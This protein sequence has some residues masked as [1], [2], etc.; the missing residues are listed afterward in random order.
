VQGGAFVGGCH[1][2]RIKRYMIDSKPG[3]EDDCFTPGWTNRWLVEYSTPEQYRFINWRTD[4]SVLT[5]VWGPD[6]MPHPFGP[7]CGPPPFRIVNDALLYPSCWQ[8]KLSPACDLSGLFT[9]RLMVEDT[10][11]GLYCDTQRV[12]I[13][14]KPITA[15]IKIDVVPEC[16]DVLVSR[17]AMPPDCGLPWPLPL[18]GIAFDEYIDPL[19]PL[20]RPNDN[21]DHYLVR[22]RKQGSAPVTIPIPGPIGNCFKGLSRVGDPGVRC[23]LPGPFPPAMLGTLAH[24]DLRAIDL[25]CNI[26]VP[27]DPAG[28]LKIARGQC[29]VYIFELF[30]YDRTRRNFSYYGYDLW[31]VKICNDLT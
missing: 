11:G 7:A 18:S 16:A 4:N 25:G 26:A 21:F 30:V 22:V 19:L 1:T 6:C 27:W 15:V 24:F 5:S 3:F 8:S 31:P 28:S 23:G 9:L 14:N 17:F 29:C 13:D 10:L 20:A 2:R 12:W